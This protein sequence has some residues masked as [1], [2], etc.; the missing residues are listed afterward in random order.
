MATRRNF[1]GSSS[2]ALLLDFVTGV[3]CRQRGMG[4]ATGFLL[5]VDPL[6]FFVKVAAIVATFNNS[7]EL[8]SAYI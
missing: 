6:R 1:T 4:L 3:V 8:M 7:L 2:S 5:T